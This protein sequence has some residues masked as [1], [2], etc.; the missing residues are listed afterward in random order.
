MASMSPCTIEKDVL[1]AMKKFRRSSNKSTMAMILRC[2]MKTNQ[3]V[4]DKELKDINV[5]QL[6]DELPSREPRFILHSHELKHA[7]GRVQYPLN[8]I[9][10]IPDGCGTNNRFTYA[11]TA[12]AVSASSG[13]TRIIELREDISAEWLNRELEKTY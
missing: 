10:Y 3:V 12:N 11:S 9:L 1:D 13:I 6:I 5:E 7:D 2:D 4:I 8:L